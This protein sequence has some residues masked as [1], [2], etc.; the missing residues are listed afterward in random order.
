MRIMIGSVLILLSNNSA[1]PPSTD[2]VVLYQGQG[3]FTGMAGTTVI[4]SKPG[5]LIVQSAKDGSLQLQITSTDPNHTGNYI[6]D[7]HVVQE[8]Q[9][10]LYQAGLSFNPAF[11]AKIDNFSTIRTMELMATNQVFDQS[12]NPIPWSST[13]GGAN[14]ANAP[15]LTWADRPTMN[16]A[17]WSHGV[18]VEAL[19]QAA[20]LAGTDLWVNM[21]INA[22]DDYIK[23]FAAYV[24]ANLDPGL[25]VHVELS[26]EVWNWAFPQAYYAQGQAEKLYGDGND[27]M[28][29]YGM[30]AAQMGA[31]WKDTFGEPETGADA[32]GRVS[33]VIGAQ[34]ENPGLELQALNAPVGTTGNI[35]ANYINEYAVTGYYGGFLSND[36]EVATVK[37]WMAQ[38]DG[39][40]TSAINALTA[41]IQTYNTPLYQSAAAQAKAYGLKLVT[42]ES[43]F[44]AQTPQSEINDPA[45]TTF[46]E[47]LQN[48]PR[49]YNIEQQN[50]AAF[51]AAGG[52]LY[53]NF[54]AIAAPSKFG[55]WGALTSVT[56]STSPR[57]QAL[58]DWNQAHAATSSDAVTYQ[59][60]RIYQAGDGG[61]TI[62]GTLHGYDVL[63][64]GA[65]NDTFVPYG[66]GATMDGMA[67]FNTVMLPGAL[68]EYT[69]TTA[70][71]GSITVSG[72]G[73]TFTAI[74]IQ[75]FVG[76]DG[77]T[78]AGSPV[79]STGSTGST[80][81]TASSGAGATTGGQTSTG[82]TQTTPSNVTSLVASGSGITAGAGD[83]H[84]GAVITLTV[85][86]S[87]AVTVSG[88]LPTL[89][90]NDGGVASYTGGSG[91]TALTFSYTVAVGQN[92]PD[93]TVTAVQL[94]NASVVT[95]GGV[96]ANLNAV[97]ANPTGTL[98]IDTSTPVTSPPGSGTASSG[99]GATTSSGSG[100]TTSSGSGTTSSSSGSTAT[101]PPTTSAPTVK[102]LV[103]SGSEITAG[104]GDVHAGSTVTLTANL[105]QVVNVSGGTPTL[106]LNDGGNRD[107]QWRIG[108]D[109]VNFHLYCGGRTKYRRS[110]GDGR[111]AQRG[112]GRDQSRSLGSRERPNPY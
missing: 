27:W 16:E 67:G 89:Q 8:S 14:I 39:G 65:G 40:Y 30:R 12:G 111:Q 42:Y 108:L 50:Y 37:A 87:Q 106:V 10:P 61:E 90:L 96:A 86:L 53:N 21:P 98:Q 83:L 9:L 3:T 46:L 32:N 2:Y 57:Y 25:K 105:S 94:N 99:S 6:R 110:G 104:A 73:E 63:V 34:L 79:T 13:V 76:S 17:T 51:T 85:N 19:V 47:N 70:T 60:A 78:S 69:F 15:Q 54:D 36:S 38:P 5:E 71:D 23:Q 59:N 45:Y 102:S 103:A 31:I 52:T 68:A 66:S 24:K 81:S 75:Q 82:S 48:D 93:L 49:I 26:N 20:N 29:W 56:E 62:A 92:T 35:A 74:S 77:A 33:I 97:V 101:T 109:R 88:G 72:Y 64:G 58:T 41:S 7:M 80:G 91:S 107:L 4:S 1:A 44:G 95:S 18:P 55:S 28:Q 84:A 43:G 100:V 11:I 22:S 112:N